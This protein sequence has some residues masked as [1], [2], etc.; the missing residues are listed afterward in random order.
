M[1]KR[2]NGEGTK[3]KKHSRGGFYKA[4]TIDGK[5]KFVYGKTKAVVAEKEKQARKEFDDGV[6]GDPITLKDFLKRWLEDSVKG[7]VR[8]STYDRY[9]KI[10]RVH[11]VP[12]LGNVKTPSSMRSWGAW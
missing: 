7:S 8:Q 11:I 1:D 4:I 10:S 2:A 6:T 12:D 3:I 9:E 5:R